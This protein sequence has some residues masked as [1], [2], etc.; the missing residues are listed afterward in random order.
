MNRSQA[1]DDG[2]FRVSSITR[3][4][5]ALGVAATAALAGFVY[6]SAPGRSTSATSS[7]SASPSS[8]GS[9]AGTPDPGSDGGGFQA[10]EQAPVPVQQAPVVRS[11][12]S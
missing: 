4:V 6:K 1:R 11:G 12:A 2:L 3:W 10:P 8:S 7:P 5:A 9:S